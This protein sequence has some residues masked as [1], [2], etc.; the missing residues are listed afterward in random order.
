MLWQGNAQ[1]IIQWS[2]QGTTIVGI[3]LDYM[4][5]QGSN[6]IAVIF[7]LGTPRKFDFFFRYRFIDR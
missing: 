2:Y 7:I 5:G 6:L 1:T 4:K 3:V